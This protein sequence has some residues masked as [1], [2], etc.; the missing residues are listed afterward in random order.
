MYKVHTPEEV[1]QLDHLQKKKNIL[2]RFMM[3]GCPGCIYSQ[4]DWDTA[5]KRAVLTPD[6]AILELESNFVEDFKNTMRPR[7][8]IDIYKFPTI[9]MIRG[10]KVT[11]LQNRDTASILKMLKSSKKTKKRVKRRRKTKRT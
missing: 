11:E 5:C 6:D 1:K 4:A 2:V 8:N 7:T 10:R 3:N 9:L